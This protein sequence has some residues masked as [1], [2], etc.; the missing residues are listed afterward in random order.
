MNVQGDLLDIGRN[1]PSADTRLPG[2]L[3][4]STHLQWSTNFQTGAEVKELAFVELSHI[5]MRRS[6]A[7]WNSPTTLV[8]KKFC[9]RTRGSFKQPPLE[10]QAEKKEKKSKKDAEHGESRRRP[11]C[12]SWRRSYDEAS[13]D[14]A[15]RVPPTPSTIPL[16]QLP[17]PRFTVFWI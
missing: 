17:I 11:G 7:R 4:P 9:E 8:T 14:P 6:Q 1:V 15:G 12:P 13:S 16:G 3:I 5:N 10:A 2:R